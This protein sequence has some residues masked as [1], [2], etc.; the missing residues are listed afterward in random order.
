MLQ[1]RYK[2]DM[3]LAIQLLQCK[4][5]SFVPQKITSVS[6]YSKKHCYMRILLLAMDV[7][8]Y[9]YTACLKILSHQK[10]VIVCQKVS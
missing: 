3:S 8:F 10:V 7:I 5:D 9:I 4:P 6:K 2:A 1:E